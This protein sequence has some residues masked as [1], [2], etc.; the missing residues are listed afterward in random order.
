MFVL[1]I[2]GL[3]VGRGRMDGGD[4]F[5]LGIDWRGLGRC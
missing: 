4:G 3:G 5:G 2:G 1:V